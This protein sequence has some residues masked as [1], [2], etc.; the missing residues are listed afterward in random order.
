MKHLIAFTLLLFSLASYSQTNDYSSYVNPFIGT[1]GHGHTYPGAT[2]PFAY[3][4]MNPLKAQRVLAQPATPLRLCSSVKTTAWLSKQH[5]SHSIQ[6]TT[7]VKHTRH[8]RHQNPCASTRH[9]IE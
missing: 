2:V 6:H 8:N 4:E 1:G 7:H 5:T 3:K 9:N